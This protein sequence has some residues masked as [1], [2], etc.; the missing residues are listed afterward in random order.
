MIDGQRAWRRSSA[1]Q[2]SK[3]AERIVELGEGAVE[4]DQRGCLTEPTAGR[5]SFGAA[6]SAA[7]HAGAAQGG[8]LAGRAL[9]E[10][11]ARR[12]PGSNANSARIA[13]AAARACSV[14]L[15]SC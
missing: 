6:G 1:R 13:S 10:L 11:A 3:R 12:R 4:P 5:A 8:A 14:S 7:G 9:L 15:S 2:P